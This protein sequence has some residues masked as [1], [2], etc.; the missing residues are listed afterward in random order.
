MSKRVQTLFLTDMLTSARKI[1]DYV[2]SKSRKDFAKNQMLADAVIRN[3]EIIG[4]ASKK[5]P[6]G[7]KQKHPEIEWKKISGLRDIL[8][9]EYFGIDYDVL[10]DIAKHKVPR[11]KEQ[12]AQVLKSSKE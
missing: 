1:I 7:I 10:W 8:V 3:L 11:L 5:I 4:E 6:A 9:H 12:I 2:G